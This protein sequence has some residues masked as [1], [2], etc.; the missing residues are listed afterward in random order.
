MMTAAS[1][2]GPDFLR[3]VKD[4]WVQEGPR[5]FMCGAMARVTWLMPFTAIYLPT[6]DLA[7]LWLVRRQQ[8]ASATGKVRV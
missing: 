6:Y 2:Q 8:S 3:V 1:G 4:I 7:T 5:Q